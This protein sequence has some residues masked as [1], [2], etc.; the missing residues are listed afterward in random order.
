M[1]N[2]PVKSDDKSDDKNG[3]LQGVSSWIF[4]S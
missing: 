1:I 4:A 3:K 2:S